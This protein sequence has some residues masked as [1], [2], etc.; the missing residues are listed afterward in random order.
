MPRPKPRVVVAAALTSQPLS[1]C[2]HASCVDVCCR[3]QK[4]LEIITRENNRRGT[5]KLKAS[6]A[7][8]VM[9]LEYYKTRCEELQREHKQALQRLMPGCAAQTERRAAAA[10]EEGE[11]EGEVA[12]LYEAE[13][14][15]LS[16]LVVEG[17]VAA[18]GRKKEV[19]EVR[20]QLA[21]AEACATESS[22][23]VQRLELQNDK[24]R[25]EL[26][27]LKTN[28]QYAVQEYD[29]V[30]AQANSLH[31]QLARVK[32]EGKCAEDGSAALQENA[33]L[34]NELLAF[35]AANQSI[36]E[37]YAGKGCLQCVFVTLCA[38]T[39]ARSS[40]WRA[41]CMMRRRT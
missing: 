5:V 40:S 32:S 17:E 21:A 24:M 2:L 28:L 29:K 19:A 30:A 35:K 41:S 36:S 23:C 8:S 34:Q 16:K 11:G 6:E 13:I 27:V 26:T 14:V 9:Q 4:K 38:G 15:R 7:E 10:S 33:R 25:E 22:N 20:A 31:Q 18:Q 3:F 1:C 37:M 39:R 12:A